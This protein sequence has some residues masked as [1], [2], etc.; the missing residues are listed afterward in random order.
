MGSLLW[1][2]PAHWLNEIARLA[3]GELPYRDFSFQYPPLAVF[4][5][6]GLLRIL[7]INF[8][9]VQ[10]IT[11]IIDFGVIAIFY[12]L[13]RKLLPRAL[14]L[15]VAFCLVAVCATSLMNFNLFSY[16]TYSPALQIGALGALLLALGLCSFLRQK[17][18]G[19][20]GGT[21]WAA[22]ACGGF[23]A[24]LSKPESA[25]AALCLVA[26]L[27]AIVRNLQS[28]ATVAA[29]VFLPALAAYA[30][31]AILAGFSNLRAG[32]T[33][34]GLATAFCPWWPTGV[35]VYGVLAA[36]GE[37]A[38]IAAVFSLPKWRKFIAAY[39]GRYRILLWTGAM[40]AVCWLSYVAFQNYGALTEPGLA[41][42]TRVLRIAPSLAYSSAVLQPVVWVCIGAFL[43][44]AWPLFRP[45]ALS[46]SDAELLMI[47]LPPVMMSSRALFGTTQSVYPEVAA[48]CYPF[49]LVL[50]PYFLWRFLKSAG[51]PR[52]A[53]IA[54]AGLTIGYGALR[55]VAGWP[56][57]LSDRKYGTLQTNAG[58]VKLLNYDTDSKVY[59]FVMQHTSQ[60][61]YV[62]D[63]P[64]GGG[65]NFA[66]GRRYPIFNVQLFGLGVPVNYEQ[67]DVS[68]MR[69][70]L[71]K[72]IIGQNE[73]GLGIYWGLGNKGERACP[74]PRLVW[75]PHRMSWDPKHL[76]PLV[77][78]IADHYQRVAT[79]GDK[80]LL[81][82]KF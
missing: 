50:G 69:Q 64:Y 38:A 15:P 29:V 81:S 18:A 76:M 71:P 16:V 73:G 56:E 1:L 19:G 37:A 24:V 21:V 14:H 40:G 79:I 12:T 10:A 70:H 75:K 11:D 48:I 3:R 57:L 5:Y 20:A 67:L 2:D 36:L 13:I 31:V 65:V 17:G 4:L 41:L 54:V 6:G 62:L 68:M 63:V 47:V 9:V 78:Y 58:T 30:A 27:G 55:T 39:G 34:Y 72:L 26:L 8:A 77:A 28:V 66:T 22:L 46:A 82:P 42:T 74:C 59:N 51:G 35:G 7:G 53:V 52:Y 23:L 32:V 45:G 80:V 44:L 25:V 33:G 61:D 49:L 60:S 43:V